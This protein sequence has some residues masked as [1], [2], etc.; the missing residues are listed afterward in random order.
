[1][2]AQLLVLSPRRADDEPRA[3]AVVDRV[4]TVVV[5]IVDVGKVWTNVGMNTTMDVLFRNDR[6]WHRSKEVIRDEEDCYSAQR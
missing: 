1:M 4:R 6:P 3:L 5:A 2:L